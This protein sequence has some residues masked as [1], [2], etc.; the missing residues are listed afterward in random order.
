MATKREWVLNLIDGQASDKV[1]VGF[2]YHFTEESEFGQALKNPAVLQR[3]IDGHQKFLEEVRPDFIKLMSDGFFDYPSPVIKKGLTSIKDLSEIS[4][5]GADHEWIEKQVELVKSIKASF[6]EDI[7]SFYNIFAP[8]TY[9][10]WQL[11]GQVAHGDDIL[12]NFLKEDPQATKTVL[13]LI[14]KDIALLV[15]RLL[16]ETAIDGIYFSVQNIQNDAISK[17]EYSHFIKPSELLVLEAAYS[18]GGRN[19][20]HICGY[21][22]ATNDVYYY[23]DYPAQVVNWAVGPEGISLAQGKELFKGKTVLGGFGNTEHDLLYQADKETIQAEAKRLVQEAGKDRLIIGAD[24]TI[25]STIASERI[26][27]VKEAI[28]E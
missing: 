6:P 10:K 1:P 22:G 24:C 9:L 18:S 20:L 3:N 25:P 12:A 7:A 17:E 26:Q 4:S 14:A 15:K 11:A 21:E 23:V 8:A 27:W 2:W 28:N 5:I 13:D 16:Q 19:I